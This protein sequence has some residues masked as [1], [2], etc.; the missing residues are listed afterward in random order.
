M[1]SELCDRRKGDR[2]LSGRTGKD[3]RKLVCRELGHGKAKELGI[4]DACVI[5]EWGL[6]IRE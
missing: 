5:S 3:M 1:Q 4:R 2:V 6:R